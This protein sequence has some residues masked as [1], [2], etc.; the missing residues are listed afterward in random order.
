VRRSPG[1]TRAALARDLGLASGTATEIA[2]RLRELHLVAETAAAGG[3]RGR[4]T[5]VLGP[6][7]AGPLVLVVEVRHEDWRVGAAEL[8]GRV[9]VLGSGRQAHSPADV[10]RAVAA[11]V[12]GA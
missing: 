6:H 1:S 2:A 7:P 3:G 9:A 4:P 8:D 5:S 10:L 11:V 12:D